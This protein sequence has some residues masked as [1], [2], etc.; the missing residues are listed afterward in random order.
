LTDS[1]DSTIIS[2]VQF[3]LSAIDVDFDVYK[4][5]TMRRQSESDTYNEVIRRL[6]KLGHAPPSS[7][8]GANLKGVMFPD[9]TQFRVTYKGRTYT[10]EIKNG[11]WIGADGVFRASPSEAAHAI[12]S[13]NVNGWRFWQ[14]KR[15]GD[16]TWQ[17]M[18]RLRSDG[19]ESA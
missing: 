12:T 1:A 11:E 3:A 10:A 2:K 7:A 13:T 8:K 6:L 5:L 18:D 16:L 19:V 14:C 9:G 15:P 4:E 17:I